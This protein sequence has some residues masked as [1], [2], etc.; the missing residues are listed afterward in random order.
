MPNTHTEPQGST[1]VEIVFF[2]DRQARDGRY[3]QAN[4]IIIR[5]DAGCV[6]CSVDPTPLLQIIV[7][8]FHGNSQWRYVIL[9]CT[10]EGNMRVEGF[11]DNDEKITNAV[12]DMVTQSRRAGRE[13]CLYS[14]VDLSILPSGLQ[15]LYL[16]PGVDR[17]PGARAKATLHVHPFSM[18][19]IVA[20]V[21]TTLIAHLQ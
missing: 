2:A 4:R 18:L 8:I 1:S 6:V 7:S 9:T 13:P 19:L 20:Y 11:P 15:R 17:Q 21:V 10:V 12:S 5:D 14:L 16:P 3:L